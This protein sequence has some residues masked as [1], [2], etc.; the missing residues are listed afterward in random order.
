VVTTAEPFDGPG[1]ITVYVNDEF[2][3]HTGYSRTEAIGRSPRMLQGPATELAPRAQ[4]RAA[5]AAWRHATVEILNYTKAGTPFWVEIDM[6]PVADET[7]WF[8]HWVSMQRDVSERHARE[9]D[10][11]ARD[12]VVQTVLDSMPGQIAILDG[13]GSILAV[14]DAWRPRR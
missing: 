9:A 1:P 3:R 12:A 8:T 2:V 5:M 7:G 11:K 14:N 13:S 4:F 6:F 10:R